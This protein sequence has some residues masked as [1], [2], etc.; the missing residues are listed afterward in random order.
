M[1]FNGYTFPRVYRLV[2]PFYA[3]LMQFHLKHMLLDV[4]I[5]ETLSC[6]YVL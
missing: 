4:Q 6:N 2:S 3:S 5:L 1:P